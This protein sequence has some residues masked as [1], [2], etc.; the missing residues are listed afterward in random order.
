M[1]RGASAWTLGGQGVC[2]GQRQAAESALLGVLTL[3]VC[4]ARVYLGYHS[5][6][7]V[8][9]LRFCTGTSCASSSYLRTH[10]IHHPSLF[11]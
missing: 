5:V 8:P 11:R 6:A 7:Q 3:A 9:S 10:V 1:Y 2:A 4:H